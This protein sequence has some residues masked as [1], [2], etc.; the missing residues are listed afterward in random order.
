[1]SSI[2]YRVKTLPSG[3]VI[4]SAPTGPAFASLNS[5]AYKVNSTPNKSIVIRAPSDFAISQL[6]ALGYHVQALPNGTIRVGVSGAATASATID[7]AARD[8]NS[9]IHVTTYST[10]VSRAVAEGDVFVPMANGG[11]RDRANS[12]R[13]L[14]NRAVP[15]SGSNATIIPPNTPRLIGDN[16][17]YPELFVPLNNS[18]RSVALLQKGAAAMGFALE[19]MSGNADKVAQP[20]VQ[21]MASGGIAATT[22]ARAGHAGSVTGP[23]IE[24]TVN[25]YNPQ[26]VPAD[27]MVNRALQYL[28]AT[29]LVK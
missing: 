21:A 25:Q 17:S 5:I 12:I 19:R 28:A 26:A 16:L 15:M 29:G 6:Q 13:G 2:G 23:H 9:T 3:K 1:M 11:L 24:M 10:S 27:V 4:V 22:A 20:N 8:R 14:F 18:A 7:N